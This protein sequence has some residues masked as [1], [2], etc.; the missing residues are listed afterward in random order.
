MRQTE[1]QSSQEYDI[2][3]RTQAVKCEFGSSLDDMIKDQIAIGVRRED[4]RKKLLVNPKLT[5]QKAVDM[6]SIEEQVEED[7]FVSVLYILILLLC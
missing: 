1:L 4:T 2:G 6:I 3:L 5:L 7:V